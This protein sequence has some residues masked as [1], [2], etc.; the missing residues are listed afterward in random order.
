MHLDP[1]RDPEH[2]DRFERYQAEALVH[3]R[4]PF[5]ALVGT[6]CYNEAGMTMLTKEL[7]ARDLSLPVRVRPEFYFR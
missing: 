4:V 6:A 3:Q 7:A 1:C 5:D 2:P